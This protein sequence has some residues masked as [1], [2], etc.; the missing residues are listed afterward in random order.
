MRMRGKKGGK[1]SN[2]DDYEDNYDKS[3]FPRP[4]KNEL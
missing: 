2:D 4:G 1:G 3:K